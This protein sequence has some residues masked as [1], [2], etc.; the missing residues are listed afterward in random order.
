MDPQYGP[1]SYPGASTVP[2]VFGAPIAGP[3]IPGM[4]IG[5]VLGMR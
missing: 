3:M 4:A 2:R 5:A 1:S